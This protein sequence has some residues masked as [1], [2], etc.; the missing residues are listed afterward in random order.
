MNAT[1]LTTETAGAKITD[2]QTALTAA[3][4][5]A[6]ALLNDPHLAKC[7]VV[8]AL[9][10]RASAAADTIEHIESWLEANPVPVPAKSSE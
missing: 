8:V 4:D 6:T 5:I 3:N 7:P 9:R 2:L 10:T 1:P